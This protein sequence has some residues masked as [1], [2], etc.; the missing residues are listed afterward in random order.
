MKA[1]I[2]SINSQYIHSSLAPWCLAAGIDAYSTSGVEYKVLEAT[3]NQ[4]DSAVLERLLSAQGD[5]YAFCCYIWNIEMIKRLIPAL[6]SVKPDAVVILGGPEV[7][8]RSREVMEEM[9]Q[10]AFVN[11]GEGEYPFARLL[12][13]LAK[14]LECIADVR[15]LRCIADV[16]GLCFRDEAGDVICREPYASKEE[17]PSPYTEKYFEALSGRIAYL[18]TSRGCPFSCSFCLSGRQ[19]QVRYF[20]LERAKSEL[21]RLANSGTQTIKLVDRTFNC[22]PARAFELLAFIIEHAGKEIPDGICF[23]FEVGADLFDDRTI[24]LLATAPAGLIQMEAGLQSFNPCTLEAVNRHTDIER[25]CQNL[26]R[27]LLPK[28]IHVHIDLIAGLPYEDGESFGRSFDKAYSLSPQ[29]LQLG[30]LKLLHGSRI[31]R[32]STEFGYTFH[33]LPPY[34]LTGNQWITQDELDSLHHTEDALDRLYN[35]GRFSRTLA[36]VLKMSGMRAFE[37]FTRFGANVGQTE[38]LSLDDF[39]ARVLAYFSTCEGVDAAVLRDMMVCDSL[40]SHSNG[41]L[42]ACLYREDKRLKKLARAVAAASIHQEKGVKRG[43]AILNTQQERVVVAEYLDRHSVTGQ[44]T[45]Q[46]FDMGELI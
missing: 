43:V 12:D 6:K 20:N 22:N 7:S 42:P 35:S 1:I 10:V 25:L 4:S 11:A 15:E 5:V 37:L 2:C 21:L 18:E 40:S 32:Q 23:H 17:P 45:L 28:N 8:F 39:T 38:R 30:F 3:I 41:R 46:Y 16:P 29:M 33:D 34:E 27:L 13:C 44:Y 31:R 26:K 19:D 24:D 14:G 36:Y 9:P